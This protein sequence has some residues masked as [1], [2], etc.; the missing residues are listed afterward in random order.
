MTSISRFFNTFAAII[1]V[2]QIAQASSI[3][4]VGSLDQTDPSLT[5]LVANGNLSMISTDP[6]DITVLLPRTLTTKNLLFPDPGLGMGDP[7]VG[8][9]MSGFD[10][11]VYGGQTAFIYDVQLYLTGSSTPVATTGPQN[12]VFQMSDPTYGTDNLGQEGW[13]FGFG[14][15]NFDSLHILVTSPTERGVTSFN[16]SLG[17]QTEQNPVPDSGSTL[18]LF[19]MAVICL[20]GFTRRLH[21]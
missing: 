10:P 5:K 11:L 3:I 1:V 14:G 15:Y 21:C 12:I 4:V 19:T 20:C 17:L 18:A 2:V 9:G 8:F 7:L 16:F 13:A 6:L